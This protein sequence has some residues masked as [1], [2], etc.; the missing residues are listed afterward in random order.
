MSDNPNL[1][2]R[3]VFF[4]LGRDADAVVIEY[5]TDLQRRMESVPTVE[6]DHDE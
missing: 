5:L 1:R 6:T 2:A 3:D 4:W